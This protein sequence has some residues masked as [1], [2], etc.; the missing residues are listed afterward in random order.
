MFYHRFSSSLLPPWRCDL[1]VFLLF[2][3]SFVDGTQDEARVTN[4]PVGT[5]AVTETRDEQEVTNVT[6][7]TAEPAI[8]VAETE[9]T[10]ESD[11]PLQFRNGRNDNGGRNDDKCAHGGCQDSAADGGGNRS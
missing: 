1:F 10:N 8:P 6:A 3:G 9:A 7:E 4:V 5:A 11:E 2:V